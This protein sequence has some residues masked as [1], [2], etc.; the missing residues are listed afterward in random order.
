MARKC[1]KATMPRFRRKARSGLMPSLTRANETGQREKV[2]LL[3]NLP[4]AGRMPAPQFRFHSLGFIC[5]HS[6][7]QASLVFCGSDLKEDAPRLVF[8]FYKDMAVA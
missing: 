2:I 5:V 1:S 6:M 4:V 7:R 8:Q 3:R